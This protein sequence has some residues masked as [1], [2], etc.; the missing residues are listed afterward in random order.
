MVTQTVVIAMDSFKGSLTAHEACSAV[1]RGLR[2]HDELSITCVQA[3][4][5]DGGEGFATIIKPLLIDTDRT[6]VCDAASELGMRPDAHS[7]QDVMQATSAA[8][9]GLLKSSLDEDSHTF[10][11]GLGG[12]RTMDCGL[13]LACA[14]GLQ[15]FDKDGAAID[16]EHAGVGYALESI[17]SAT[18]Q[19]C[20]WLRCLRQRSVHCIAAC[21]VQSPLTGQYGAAQMFG[22]QKGA[23]AEQRQ[24]LEDGMQ[25]FAMVLER[26]GLARPGDQF[27]VGAG[28]AG[29]LGFALSVFLGASIEQGFEIM[30]A[31]TE[32]DRKI[33][34]SSLVV[35][36]EGKLDHQTRYGKVAHGVARAAHIAGVPCVAIVGSTG[37][38]WESLLKSNRYAEGFDRVIDA[39]NGMPTEAALPIA[40]QL[41]TQAAEGVMRS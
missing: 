8:L 11:I 36:G 40:A 26:E 39:S 10:I 19:P 9:A 34:H 18:F 33:A 7:H 30:R 17:H 27:T 1:E 5:S 16:V 37:S 35:T 23:N 15:V 28:A 24:R 12:T 25:N 31:Q 20:E 2:A 41:I 3:P 14:L 29:G 38:G 32:L 13:G 6:S 4:M 22:A 21:D